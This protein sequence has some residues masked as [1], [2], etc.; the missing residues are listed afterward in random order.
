MD[1]RLPHPVRR[2]QSISQRIDDISLRMQ[3]GMRAVLA[4]KKSLISKLSGDIHQYNPMHL[5]RLY[6]EKFQYLGEQLRRRMTQIIHDH[7]THMEGIVHGL[8]TVSPLATL[9]RGYSIVMHLDGTIVRDAA[10]VKPGEIIQSRLSKGKIRSQIT[11][12]END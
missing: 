7:R 10:A 2:L 9:D 11:D 6:K 8:H 12:I 5:L 3:Q 4:E 1:K